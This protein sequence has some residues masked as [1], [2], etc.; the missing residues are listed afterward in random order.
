MSKA[1]KVGFEKVSQAADFIASANCTLSLVEKQ[2]LIQ[3]QM[4]LLPLHQGE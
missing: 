4:I 2:N 1:Y 3:S